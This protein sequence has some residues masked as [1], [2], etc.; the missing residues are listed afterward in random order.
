MS[1]LSLYTPRYTPSVW[2]PSSSIWDAF[3]SFEPL[4]APSRSFL[5]RFEVLGEGENADQNG[6]TL[7]LDL[8]GFKREEVTL[9]VD[10]HNVLTVK[11]SRSGKRGQETSISRSITLGD[12]VNADAISAKL[13]HGVLTVTVPRRDTPKARQIQV[14]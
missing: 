12:D 7:T 13:E 8:P 11:A 14:T 4:L 10:H 9:E 3:A 6:Y 5:P 1:I 2:S